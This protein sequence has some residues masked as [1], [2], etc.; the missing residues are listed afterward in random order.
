MLLPCDVCDPR[1]RMVCKSRWKI[2][3]SK[4][5]L[6]VPRMLPWREPATFL[7]YLVEWL[8]CLL[9]TIYMALFRCT[10]YVLVAPLRYPAKILTC[11]TATEQTYVLC[12][13]SGKQCTTAIRS[14]RWFMGLVSS[15]SKVT[16][17][18]NKCE[19][20]LT[21]SHFFPLGILQYFW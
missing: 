18:V 1:H 14:I 8:V 19:W 6:K 13:S 4:S 15:L 2:G 11:R 21:I 5:V 3:L 12:H 7:E 10:V 20:L 16:F 17:F 9:V